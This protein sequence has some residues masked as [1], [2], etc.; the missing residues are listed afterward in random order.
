MANYRLV[1]YSPIGRHVEITSSYEA[2]SLIE[3]AALL[4]RK[5]A[6]F[7]FAVTDKEGFFIWPD[8]I[9]QHTV[10]GSAGWGLL[11]PPEGQKKPLS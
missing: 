8:S 4:T 9:V 10:K 6:G 1:K 11:T 5:N 7:Q 2:E 3:A